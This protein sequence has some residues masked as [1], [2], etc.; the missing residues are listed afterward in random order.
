MY[1]WNIFANKQCCK[2]GFTESGAGSSIL[3]EWIRIRIR[4]QGFDDQK[5]N[6]IT[7]EKEKP[8]ALKW[9]HSALQKMK[10]INFFLFFWIIL[11]LL[12]PDPDP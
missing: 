6:K 10:F 7:V 9:V 12:N 5:F 4:N 3:S 1:L 11:V 8:S 2:S